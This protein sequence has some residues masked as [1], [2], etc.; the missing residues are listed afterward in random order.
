VGESLLMSAGYV[1]RAGQLHCENVSLE[2]IA[3]RVGTPVYV[4]SSAVIRRQYEHLA[5][6]LVGLPVHVHYSVKANPSLAILA[7]LKSLGA[8]VDIVSGGEL[9]RALKAG[10]T[11]Q[12]IVFS[13]VGKTATELERALRAGVRNINV[14]SEG[15]LH[16]LQ[17]V[18]LRLGVIAPVALRVNPDVAVD[19]PHRYTRTGERGMKFG[20]PHDRILSVVQDMAAMPNLKLTGLA[21]HLGSQIGDAAPYALAAHILVGLKQ[22]IEAGGLGVITTLDL[23]GGLGVTYD[24]E[25]PPDLGAYAAALG[26]AAA[27]AG[28]SV[29]VEPGR[30]LVAESGVLLTRVLYRKRSGGKNIVITDAGMNDFIRPS[31]YESHHAIEAVSGDDAPALRADIVGPVCESGDFFANDRLIADVAAGD[32]I[33]LRATGAYGYSMASN[34]NSRPRPAEVL[35]DDDRFAVI[36]ERESDADLTRRETLTPDWIE[37]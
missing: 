8:G 3:Q 18:A 37:D 34:Y 35:V 10:F 29:L 14:E 13:G 23:G 33:A 22:S 7:L 1:R 5:T 24:A 15:E 27:E 4:Y 30:F 26:I 16:A 25:V 21:A 28:V 11:G 36:T 9:S 31:L 19:T 6:A 17:D 12:E 20:I 32:L 2:T